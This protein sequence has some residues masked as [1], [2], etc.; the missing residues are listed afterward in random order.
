MTCRNGEHGLALFL[1][2]QKLPKLIESPANDL[3]DERTVLYPLSLVSLDARV[4]TDSMQGPSI[5]LI[6]SGRTSS[7]SVDDRQRDHRP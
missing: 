5:C 4:V 1:D 6:T 3:T 7:V 2:Y